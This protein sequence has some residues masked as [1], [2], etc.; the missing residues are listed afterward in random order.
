MFLPERESLFALCRPVTASA[1]EKTTRPLAPPGTPANRRSLSA[2]CSAFVDHREQQFHKLVGCYTPR[3]AVFASIGLS[4]CIFCCHP[5]SSHTVAFTYAALQHIEFAFFDGE[6]N[7]LHV[8]VMLLEFT[9]VTIQ[10][11]IESGHQFLERAELFAFV[12]SWNIHLPG[13][14]RRMPATHIFALGVHQI[15]HRIDSRRY[16]W[17]RVKTP[18]QLSLPILPKYHGLYVH[19]CTPLIRNLFD[20]AV[21]DGP[22]TVPAGEHGADA[23]PHLLVGILRKFGA[24][25]FLHCFLIVG[26]QFFQLVNG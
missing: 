13:P 16:P 14:G 12:R 2:S 5:Y 20:A 7:V 4:L 26:P 3:T 6:L 18:V 22:L 1:E 25:H 21:L 19:G 8:F 15:R 9:L 10:F 11:F 24:Q 17:L 23:A